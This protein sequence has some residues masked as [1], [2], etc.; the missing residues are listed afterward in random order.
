MRFKAASYIKRIYDFLRLRCFLSSLLRILGILKYMKTRKTEGIEMGREFKLLCAGLILL[1]LA[2]ILYLSIWLGAIFLFIL[3]P[4]SVLIGL[5]GLAIYVHRARNWQHDFSDWEWNGRFLRELKG[6]FER[7]GWTYAPVVRHGLNTPPASSMGFYLAEMQVLADASAT[8]TPIEQ[9]SGGGTRRLCWRTIQPYYASL[10][11]DYDIPWNGL[12]EQDRGILELPVNLGNIAQHGF[13]EFEKER[14][15]QL[16][17]GGLVSA[18]LHAWNDFSAIKDWV[19][20]LKRNYDVRFVRADEYAAIYMKQ[21]PRPILIDSSLTPFWAFKR[22]DSLQAIREVDDGIISIQFLQGHE[23]P[24]QALLSVNTVRPI[25][26]IHID[27]N[28]LIWSDPPLD[29]KVENSGTLLKWVKK[30]TYCLEV[31]DATNIE[32]SLQ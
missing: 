11:K 19:D 6:S 7:M 22:G 9:Q 1:S 27:S 8:P 2:F 25:P 17:E 30:G 4:Y 14:I 10:S 13:G 15:E 12:D 3:I 20:Y 23:T 26:E 18:F 29:F 5:I 16:P 28:R 21:N 32:E 31:Q 24:R